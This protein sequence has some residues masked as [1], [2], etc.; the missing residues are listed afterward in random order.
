MI[1]S[2]KLQV[3][4]CLCFVLFCGKVF[5]T[6]LPKTEAVTKTSFKVLLRGCHSC[7]GK[8]AQIWLS[9]LVDDPLATY[10]TKLKTNPD[11]KSKISIL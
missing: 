10:L 3:A 2:S 6:G 1:Y 7:K 5:A 9:P 4:L 11:C 8:M